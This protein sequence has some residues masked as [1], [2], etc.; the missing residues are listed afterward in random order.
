MRH[1]EIK[2]T[3]D[4]IINKIILHPL[5]GPNNVCSVC[6]SF[7]IHL[8]CLLWLA[9][10]EGKGSFFPLQGRRRPVYSCA[11]CSDQ[12]D[13]GQHCLSCSACLY[14]TRGHGMSHTW[15]QCI[16]AMPQ[17]FTEPLQV[18]K[19]H[20]KVMTERCACLCCS[21]LQTM[22]H[23]QKQEGSTVT[24]GNVLELVLF[25]FKLLNSDDIV[26][27]LFLYNTF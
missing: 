17:T 26:N 18:D 14:V 13:V 16:E 15:R 3:G 4:I 9:I 20:T 1:F 6:S 23:H 12:W 2:Q 22:K 10:T 25:I 7:S 8:L 5:V 24:D 19:Y 21:L 27:S 11:L